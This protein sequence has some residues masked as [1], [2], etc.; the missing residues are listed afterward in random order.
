MASTK[1]ISSFFQA[2]KRLKVT[3]DVTNEN[4]PPS[5]GNNVSKNDPVVELKIDNPTV[6]PSEEKAEAE[7]AT[8]AVEELSASQGEK[9]LDV[10]QEQK[11]RM[12]INKS[13][14]RAKRNLR[15][16]EE[17]VAEAKGLSSYSAITKCL[18][19]EICGI[20]WKSANCSLS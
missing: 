9:T 1:P 8:L 18:L 16:C 5:S 14:A 20:T 6:T 17:R 15:L 13:A 7:S 10:T 11:M 3:K 2:P 4:D 19:L 12:E